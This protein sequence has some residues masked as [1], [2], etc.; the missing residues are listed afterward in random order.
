MIMSY[1]LGNHAILPNILEYETPILSKLV[2]KF[3]YK[4]YLKLDNEKYQD[5]LS[6]MYTIFLV[7]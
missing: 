1:R 7:L 5:L 2:Y 3:A 4:N 6:E